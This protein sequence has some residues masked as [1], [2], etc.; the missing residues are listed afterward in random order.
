MIGTSLGRYEITEQLGAGGM[1]VVYRAWDTRLERDVALKILPP[2][3]VADESTRKRFRKE[4][5]ALSRLNHP[6]IA[7]IHDFDSQNGVDFLVMELIPG[8]TLSGKVPEKELVKL[9][10]QL[11]QGLAAAHSAG[12]LHR[13]LK[14]SNLRVTPDGRLKILDFGLA[15]LQKPLTTHAETDTAAIAGGVAGTIPYMAPE[16]LRGESIDERTDVYGAG[17]ALYE[18]L[19]GRPP[20]IDGNSARLI[21][22]IVNDA[23]PGLR[24]LE[25]LVSPA[26]EQVVLK[27]LDKDPDRRYQSAK[28]LAVDLA[29][30]TGSTEAARALPEPRV[31]MRRGVVTAMAIGAVVVAVA[32]LL[33]AP[34]VR[35]RLP[36]S[37]RHVEHIAVLP[38][39][40]AS[41]DPAQDHFADGV[42][43]EL[44][45]ALSSLESLQVTSPMTALTYRTRQKTLPEI[46]AELGVSKVVQGSVVRESQRARIALELIDAATGQ[47]L[48]SHTYEPELRTILSAHG[49]VAKEIAREVGARV[50]REDSGRLTI[51]PKLNPDAHDAYLKGVYVSMQGPGPRT[52][53]TPQ[54]T[55]REYW[56]EATRIDPTFGP[57]WSALAGY[58]VNQGFFQQTIPPMEAYPKAKELALKALALDDMDSAA[59]ANIAT[60]K[61]HHEWDWD[62]A[63]ASFKRALESN[64]SSAMGHHTYAHHLLATGRLE[65]S[66]VETRKA[67]DLDPLNPYMSSCVGWHCLFARQ[68]DEAIQQCMRIITDDRAVP[69]TYF[70]LG[71]VYV[72][73]GK[74]PEAIAALQ[75]AV[76]KNPANPMVATLGYALGRAGRREEAMQM[77]G[78][79]EERAKKRYV[80]AFDFAVVYSGLGED[81]RVFEWL[82]KAFLERSTWLVHIGWDDRFGQYRS[83]S[84]FKA[85]LQRI[86]L[87]ST[88]TTAQ[89]AALTPDQR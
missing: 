19:T 26:V 42:S 32:V 28:E 68:Y 74:L 77:L 72:Q 11:A 83:D 20:F 82:D 3:T 12:V 4:A 18:L 25:P 31:R 59:H 46:A 5:L 30:L 21:Q 67:S 55:A 22:S 65:E 36:S 85:L 57:A 87:P 33:I 24:S 52:A 89:T 47:R 48:W 56:E 53:G 88:P 73:T 23:P 71:R 40:N 16:Q 9:G 13:D 7:T 69:L 58:Y 45:R 35:E 50:T 15:R 44:A 14:P 63:E 70:Y 27:A 64:P 37:P 2:G 29:R 8:R 76:E 17:A 84:R 66:V 34:Q 78:T 61:L 43:T 62:G 38:L 60:V 54:K 86:G 39:T 79:L 1:G 41:G 81:D 6:N 75:T 49:A 10:M 80:S 51:K